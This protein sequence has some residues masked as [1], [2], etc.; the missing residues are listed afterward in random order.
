M[1]GLS[2]GRFRRWWSAYYRELPHGT[3]YLALMMIAIL[4]LGAGF[5]LYTFRSQLF[6]SVRQ[7]SANLARAFEQDV[8]HSLREA[9]WTLLLLR[10]YYV[11]QSDSFDFA[12]MTKK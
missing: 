12:S 7:N 11:R 4:W 10:T 9:D 1:G 3:A 5:H 6:D 8:L 2:M